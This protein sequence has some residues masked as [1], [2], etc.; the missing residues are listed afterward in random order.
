MLAASADPAA[1]QRLAGKR[2]VLRAEALR[3]EYAQRREAAEQEAA[4]RRALEERL[5]DLRRRSASMFAQAA[6]VETAVGAT[7]DRL[8]ERR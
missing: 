2:E 8:V 3:L 5:A 7:V 1:F 6:E 4:H